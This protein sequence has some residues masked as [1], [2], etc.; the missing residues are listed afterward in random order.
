[1]ISH[2]RTLRLRIPDEP[3][4]QHGVMKL[5]FMMESSNRSGLLY[6]ANMYSILAL[7]LST[8]RECDPS[9]TAELA[10]TNNNAAIVQNALGG[11]AKILNCVH[12]GVW[13]VKKSSYCGGCK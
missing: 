7:D 11:K 10:A 3:R 1:M 2:L 12:C 9:S 6:I 8:V 13:N 4:E 5:R